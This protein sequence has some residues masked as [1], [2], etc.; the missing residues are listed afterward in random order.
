MKDVVKTMEQEILESLNPEEKKM[1]NSLAE[2]SIWS[3][4]FDLYQGK[5][6][7]LMIYINIVI[8]LFFIGFVHCLLEFFEATEPADLIK[9]SFGSV[10]S[11]VIIGMMKLFIWMQLDKYE[12]LRAVKRAEFI[13]WLHHRKLTK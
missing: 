4:L 13:N 10:L 6:K 7:W 5:L 9:W 1:Y 11:I 3:Q 8:L 12:V 2:R